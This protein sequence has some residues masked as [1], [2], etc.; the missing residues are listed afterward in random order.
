MTNNLLLKSLTK[1]F[2]ATVVLNNIDLSFAP[3]TVTAIVGDNGAGKSTL[4]K[5]ITGIY[6]L[7]KGSI[8]LNDILISNFSPDQIRDFGIEMVYQ[9]LALAPQQDVVT[10]LFIG[11]EKTYQPIGILKRRQMQKLAK[12]VLADL[13]ITIN[14]LNI[15]VQNLSGGQQQVIAI[16]RALLFEPKVLIMDE[17]TAALAVKE[18]GHVLEL[19][20]QLRDKGIIVIFI[21]HRLNDVFAVSD[22]IITLKAGQVVAENATKEVSMQDVVGQIVGVS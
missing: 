15:K 16:A 8:T 13:G 9:D 7:N 2:G 18:I 21:S 22:R 1:T 17:P 10:N 6:K 19:I 20:K 11:R 12:E 14:N 3:G 4:C 5:T